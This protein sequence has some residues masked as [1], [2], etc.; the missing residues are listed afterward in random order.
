MGRRRWCRGGGPRLWRGLL[1]GGPEAVE[2]HASTTAELIGAGGVACVAIGALTALL[3]RLTLLARAATPLAAV[4]AMPLTIY[5][6]Q[7]VALAIYLVPYEPFDFEAW[8]SWSLLGV[9][10][11]GSLVAAVVWRRFVGQGPLEWLLS[12]AS[13]R[14]PGQRPALG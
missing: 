10:A 3:Q 12:R 9:F 5:S 4:G 7:L 2:A 8:R 14:P 11:I 1:Q 6:L 13:L